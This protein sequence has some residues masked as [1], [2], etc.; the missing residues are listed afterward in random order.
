MGGSAETGTVQTKTAWGGGGHPG[1]QK[2][3]QQIG[4]RVS[5]GSAKPPADQTNS[6]VAGKTCPREV[7]TKTPDEGGSDRQTLDRRMEGKT[8]GG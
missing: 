4:R 5:G 6:T 3:D 1:G 2:A 8:G 7:D